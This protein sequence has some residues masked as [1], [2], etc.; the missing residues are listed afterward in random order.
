MGPDYFVTKWPSAIDNLASSPI[1]PTTPQTP[2]RSNALSSK[3]TS[4]LSASYADLEIKDALN[5][6]DGRGVENNA[7]TRRRLRLD[8]QKDVI[9]SNGAVIKEFGHVAEVSLSLSTS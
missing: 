6:L 1:S 4:V 9:E 8:I 2:L 7:E 5:L 3:V